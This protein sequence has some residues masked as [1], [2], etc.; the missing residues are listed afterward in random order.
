MNVGSFLAMD[1]AWDPNRFVQPPFYLPLPDSG[2]SGALSV[3]C[4]AA[5]TVDTTY[6]AE[7]L[8]PT[9]SGKFRVRAYRHTVRKEEGH[10]RPSVTGILCRASCRSA[11]PVGGFAHLQA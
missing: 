2:R 1:F 7:T 5:T 6:V 3:R 10:S 8:L 11:R 4:D 9:R